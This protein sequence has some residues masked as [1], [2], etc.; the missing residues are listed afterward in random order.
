MIPLEH[1]EFRLMQTTVLFLTETVTNL[2]NALASPGKQA[3]HAHFWRSV[4]DA[5][6]TGK[7]D[8]IGFGDENG[9]A[10]GG[11]DFDIGSLHKK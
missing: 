5:L 11:I 9:K 3:F 1:G 7:R 10:N 8:D 2:K 6:F 4:Q